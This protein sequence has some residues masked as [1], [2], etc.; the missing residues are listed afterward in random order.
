MKVRSQKSSLRVVA[1][2][3]A[4]VFVVSA[5]L[6]VLNLLT[7]HHFRPY[8]SDD[9]SWQNILLTWR[10]HNGHQ[11]ILGGSDSFIVKVPFFWLLGH[12]FEPSRR[13][14]FAEATFFALLSLSLYYYAFLYFL[15]KLKIERTYLTLLPFV[16]FAS[17]G[18]GIGQMSLNPILRN[19]ELGL[20]FVYFA[21]AAK[22]YYKELDGLSKWV[23]WP[24]GICATVLAGVLVF[25][26][27]YFLYFTLGPIALLYLYLYITKR[28][29][30]AKAGLLAGSILA[31]MVVAKAVE[32]LA[33]K[34]G[35]HL[36]FKQPIQFVT[37][38]GL[39]NNVS[40][41]IHG[42]LVIFGADFFGQN[43]LSLNSVSAFLD[44]VV[45]GLLGLQLVRTIKSW[46]G[47][48]LLDKP[49]DLL[50]WRS[51]LVGVTL[52][53]LA[54]YIFSNVAV[55]LYSYRY[56]II[57]VYALVLF[58]AISLRSA[59]YQ[60]WIYGLLCLAI[61]GNFLLFFNHNAGAQPGS[62][63]NVANSENKFLIDT[64]ASTGITKGYATY[65][66]GNIN[67]YLSKGHTEFLPII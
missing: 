34:V 30:R 54:V 46:R 6:V 36:A 48:K 12:F 23:N 44:L 16:W 40:L 22:L 60:G 20:S 55:D 28:V 37:F 8:N 1:A 15:K 50:L 43:V 2:P 58:L 45:L 67:S 62:A 29:S 56:L 18:F 59:R 63:N 5:F 19:F 24:I 26:D 13:L 64:L 65:W 42:L 39:W 52:L 61:V 31:S 25:N 4:V 66:D 9:V 21:L 51:F 53:V 11:V 10:P 17:F 33:G 32:V 7:I 38:D 27:P 47:S 41:A 35:L 14:I 49:S 3:V 57:S